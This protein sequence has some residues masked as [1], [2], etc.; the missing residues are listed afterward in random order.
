LCQSKRKRDELEA[1]EES[2]P[3]PSALAAEAPSKKKRKSA[4]D[5]KREPATEADLALSSTLMDAIRGAPSTS[6][7]PK[8]DKSKKDKSKK[9]K[10]SMM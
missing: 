3:E 1:S 9:E 5:I 8:K 2:K 4:D 6:D 10:F 7:K